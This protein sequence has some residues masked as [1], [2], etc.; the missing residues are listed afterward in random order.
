MPN[1]NIEAEQAVLGS[2]LLSKEKYPEVDAL[3]SSA[4]F[5]S[6]VHKE[7]Y[8]CIKVLADQGKGIDH[9]TVSKQLDRNNALKRVGGIDY[10][11]E[12]QTIPVSALAADSYANLV[13]DQSIDRNLRKVLQELINLSQDPKGKSSDEVLNE[14]ESKIFELS[15]NRS[16]ED[17]LKKIDIYVKETLDKLDDLSKKTGDLVGISSGFKAIDGVTQGLKPEELIVI[18]GRPSMGKT[19]LAMNIA[20]NVAKEEDGCVLVF[21][22]EMSSQSLTSRMIGSMAGISQ[23]SIMLGR[24]L[25]DRQW[26]KIVEKS[27]RLGDMNIFIDDTANIN[28]MEI[29]AKS[30]RL[31]KQFRKEGGVKLIVIDY[32]Q[33]MQ[34][35]GRNDNRVNELSDISRALKH[36]AKEVKAPVIVLSQLNRSVEQRPNKRPQMSD[37]RDSGAIEQD[38]DLIF[39]LYRD[40][41]YKKEEEWKSVAEVRLVKHRNGPTKDLLLSFREELTKFGDLAPEIMNSYAQD[42]TSD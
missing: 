29:R 10:L 24:N 39:M 41:V 19:S 32:I 3:L 12:L 8:E 23:Q 21:S 25:T 26:E 9:I 20:E 28:P 17:S 2:L 30:R 34:M 6:E 16:K 31:A 38:A 15:E 13:K 36:L 7:I 22:L 40:Y 18:A 5:E 4:D 1:S 37:L 27:R 14:A 42:R 33:L 11:K 35:P